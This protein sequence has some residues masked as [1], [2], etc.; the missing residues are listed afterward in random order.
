MWK[1]YKKGETV[2]QAMRLESQTRFIT[3][4]RLYTGRAGQW[5]VKP[6]TAVPKELANPPGETHSSMKGFLEINGGHLE[7]AHHFERD[8]VS[9]D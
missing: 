9:I 1:N 2:V 3:R 7:E 8:Y 6:Q 5:I 4:N